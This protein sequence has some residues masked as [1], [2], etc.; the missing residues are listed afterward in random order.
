MSREP[1]RPR[2]TYR[3]FTPITTRWHDNDVYGHVNNVVYY[4]WFD[5]AVNAWLIEAGLLDVE[6]GNPIGLVVETGCRYAASVQFPQK[7][8]VGIR[9]A[10]LGSSSVT[11]HLGIFVEGSGA[12]AAE[13]HFTHVYVDRDSRRPAPLPEEWRMLLETIT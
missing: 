10:R 6:N 9:V 7:L 5:T 8:E 3:H 4:S 11:Y 1:L 2:E 13:G 12:A